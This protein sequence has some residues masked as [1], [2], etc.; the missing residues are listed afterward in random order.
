VRRG[1]AAIPLAG[2]EE[3]EESE[4]EENEEDMRAQV[5]LITC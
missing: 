3:E 2:W 5:R 1:S 4:E